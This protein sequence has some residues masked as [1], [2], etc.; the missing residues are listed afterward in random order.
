MDRERRLGLPRGVVKRIVYAWGCGDSLQQIA[1]DLTADGIATADGTVKW[2]AWM[3]EAI[4]EAP[5]C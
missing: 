4:L 5:E 2:E 1:N 3:V